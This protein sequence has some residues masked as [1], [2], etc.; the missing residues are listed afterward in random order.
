VADF[1][2]M[3][4]DAAAAFERQSHRCEYF[5]P[6]ARWLWLILMFYMHA[7]STGVDDGQLSRAQSSATADA[8][9]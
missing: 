9:S 7:F 2:R 3:I 4:F 5:R 1:K 8:I 6:N